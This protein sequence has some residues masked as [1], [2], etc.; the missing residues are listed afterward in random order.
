[1]VL[2]TE[3]LTGYMILWHTFSSMIQFDNTDFIIPN[4]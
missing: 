4:T 1:L 3:K 2:A